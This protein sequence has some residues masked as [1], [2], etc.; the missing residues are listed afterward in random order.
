MEAHT[1][2][3][4]IGLV[5]ALQAC[6]S[7]EGDCTLTLGSTI[8]ATGV[9]HGTLHCNKDGRASV[10]APSYS[11]ESTGTAVKQAEQGKAE[12]TRA[13]TELVKAETEKAIVSPPPPKVIVVPPVIKPKGKK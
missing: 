2:F 9:S 8:E 4:C 13:Q 1:C 3:G 5:W 10:F 12:N 6:V 11:I 7:I